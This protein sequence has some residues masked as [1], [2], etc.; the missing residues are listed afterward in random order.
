MI[1][2]KGNKLPCILITIFTALV[3]TGNFCLGA[4]ELL[5]MAELGTQRTAGA[6]GVVDSFIPPPAEEPAI[7]VRTE[8]SQFVP[9]RVG[10]QRIF[11]PSGTHGTASAFYQPCFG[12]LSNIN[13]INVKNTIVLKLRI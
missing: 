1:R 13:Y 12:A 6:D 11:N 7:F 10:F 3:V 8:D 2:S 9:L 4:A 5:R